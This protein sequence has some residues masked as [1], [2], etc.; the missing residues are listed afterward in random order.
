MP[1]ARPHQR[2][3]G[4]PCGRLWLFLGALLCAWVLLPSGS[5][6]SAWAQDAS[7]APPPP[8]ENENE[9]EQARGLPIGSVKVA[10]NRRITGEDIIAYLTEKVGQSFSP[11]AL[12]KDVR[13][14]WNS[15]YAWSTWALMRPAT[16]PSRTPRK[17]CASPCL[18]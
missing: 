12:S 17:S 13:E 14:L 3:R 6:T 5:P 16:R 8:L 15:L 4:V 18:K 10:G 2:T 7:Q 11:E 9:T 1:N